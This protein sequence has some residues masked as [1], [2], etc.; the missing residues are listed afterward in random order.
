M[1]R[2]QHKLILEHLDRYKGDLVL[3]DAHLQV[4]RLSRMLCRT[5]R[6]SLPV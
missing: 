1:H 5:Q 4:S 6:V 2:R 3:L